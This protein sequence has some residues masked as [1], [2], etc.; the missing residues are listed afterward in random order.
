MSSRTGRSSPRPLARSLEPLMGESLG[1]YLLRL[2]YRLRVSPAE[3]ARLTGCADEGQVV[4]RRSLLLD[5]D[6]QLFAQATRMSVDEANALV[7]PSWA[8]RYPPITRSRTRQDSSRTLDG[9]LFS[10][11]HRYC[12]DCLAGNGSPVQQQYGGP[13]K[14]IWHLPIAFACRQHH[15]FLREG[16]PQPHPA[17]PGIWRLIPFPS[18]SALHPA[19]CRLPLH[20]GKT[21][22][23]R[24]Y[25]GIRLDQPGKDDPLRPGPGTL[26]VQGCLLG[27]LSSKHPAE[28]ASRTFTD[29]RVIAALLCLSWPLA[30]DTM[31]PDLAAAVS[32]H[33]RLLGTSFN[34]P[35]DRQPNNVLATA[36]LLTAAVTVLS[37]P[38]LAATVARHVR[39]CQTDRPGPS[40]WARV[41]GR[42]LAACSPA[43]REAISSL[44]NSPSP[45]MAG[46]RRPERITAINPQAVLPSFVHTGAVFPAGRHGARRD[47]RKDAAAWWAGP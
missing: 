21:G 37:S 24:P 9:W 42:H 43:L 5:M 1:G 15:R 14:K 12:P 39:E 46:G 47:R 27:L 16:C 7:L 41:L 44:V 18:A 10:T 23:H 6:V 4:I 3:L 34:V 2:S 35:L 19:E 28:D 45:V 20:D 29:L 38:D 8:D 11:S 26:D 17:Y 30:E 40:W 36:G 22:R 32:Q 25:C 13:W 33:V 31:D